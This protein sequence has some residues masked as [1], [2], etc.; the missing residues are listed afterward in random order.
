MGI[1]EIDDMFG[2]GTKFRFI[3]DLTLNDEEIFINCDLEKAFQ[4]KRIADYLAEIT[5]IVIDKR[6]EELLK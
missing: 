6:Q 3:K 5:N 4:L 1:E 2:N